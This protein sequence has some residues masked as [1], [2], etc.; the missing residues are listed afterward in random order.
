MGFVNK[1]EHNSN[2]GIQK[3][4]SVHCQ[5]KEIKQSIHLILKLATNVKMFF[6]AW[7]IQTQVWLKRI[8]YDRLPKYKTLGV[9]TLSVM[10]HGF[11][12][13]YYFTFR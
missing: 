10:W 7:N 5:E 6:D 9:F 3:K 13:G 4:I 8:C 1:C 2:R 12:P 11:Y